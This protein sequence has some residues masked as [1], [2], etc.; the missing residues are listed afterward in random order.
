MPSAAKVKVLL[1]NG[2]PEIGD[3]IFSAFVSHFP[4]LQNIALP[5]TCTLLPDQHRQNVVIPALKAIVMKSQPWETD[6]LSRITELMEA[7]KAG[8]VKSTVGDLFE[9]CLASAA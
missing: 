8:T 6:P 9:F 7:T 5:R 2:I 3:H 4:E 1:N